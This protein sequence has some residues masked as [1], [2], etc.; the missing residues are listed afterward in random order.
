MIINS[1][2]HDKM[3]SNIKIN[4]SFLNEAKKHMLAFDDES[5]NPLPNAPE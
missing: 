4:K 1:Y 5:P 3:K 2:F